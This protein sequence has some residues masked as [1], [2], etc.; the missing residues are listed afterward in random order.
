MGFTF[1]KD[2]AVYTETGGFVC[3]K[4][5]QY[6]PGAPFPEAGRLEDPFK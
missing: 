6:D 1:L 2:Q 5:A 4:F 3:H